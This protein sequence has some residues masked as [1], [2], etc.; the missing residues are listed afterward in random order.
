LISIV[1]IA[2]LLPA[3]FPNHGQEK[4]PGFWKTIRDAPVRRLD[5]VGAGLLLAASVLL[6]FAFE[7]AGFRYA[8]SSSIVISTLTV[9]AVAFVAFILWEFRAERHSNATVHA[10][11]VVPVF[12]LRLVK[13]RKLVGLLL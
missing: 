10:V 5:I 1:I 13:N 7:E 12:P 6:V 3:H 4:A 8:W 9:G 11:R 2:L